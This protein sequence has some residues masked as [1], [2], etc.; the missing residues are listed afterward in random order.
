M[1]LLAYVLSCMMRTN[2]PKLYKEAES[3]PVR[4][5]R[6][7]VQAYKEDGRWMNWW[8]RHRHNMWDYLTKVATD[9]DPSKSGN[10]HQNQNFESFHSSQLQDTVG[11][12]GAG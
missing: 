11:S 7:L 5:D 3:W 2:R 9:D 10:R 8:A 4:D 12:Q 1:A 6:G